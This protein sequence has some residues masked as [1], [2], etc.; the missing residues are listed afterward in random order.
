[1]MTTETK[2]PTTTDLY[3]WFRPH[4]AALPGPNRRD[5]R[6]WLHRR[7][8]VPGPGPVMR[9]WDGSKL[10]GFNSVPVQTESGIVFR[11]LS[12]KDKNKAKRQ[13]RARS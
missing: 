5:W 7:G 4:L 11:G 6:R 9:P 3:G 12:G 1:M 2:T 10:F 13:R 8:C